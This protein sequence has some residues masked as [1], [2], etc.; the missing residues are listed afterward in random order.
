MEPEQPPLSE[1]ARLI[2]VFI[3]PR[4]TFEDIRRNASWWVPWL[5]AAVFTLL[6]GFVVVQKVD[7]P[8]LVEKRVEQ[9]K[10]AQSR[11]EQL[12]PAQREQA[13]QLQATIAKVQF[14]ARPAVTL[15]IGLVA[16]AILMVIFNFGFAAE[17][18]FAQS[19]AVTFYASLPG[20]VRSILVIVSLLV[21]SD[22]G[23]IDPDI[24]PVATNPAF[25]MDREA[26]RFLYGLASGLD[27]IAIWTI[28]LTA[29]GFVAVCKNR[30]LTLGAALSTLLVIYGLLAVGGAALGAAF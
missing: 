27:A 28:V 11:M 9:S 24:N 2:N 15:I 7:I 5:V 12:T 29:I 25:F 26:N 22:P 20:V 3:A 16:A 13:M 6:M 14:F 19:L 30:K 10:M 18:S 23:G 1:A 8:R 17:V 4:K 21:S